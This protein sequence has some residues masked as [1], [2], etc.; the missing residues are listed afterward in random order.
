MKD[1]SRFERGGYI[2][3]DRKLVIRLEELIEHSFKSEHHPN[4]YA[5]EMKI[6]MKRLNSYTM[7]Y[8]GKTVNRMIEDR[9]HEEALK[10]LCS[11]KL[12]IKDITYL[13]GVNDPSWFSRCFKKYTGYSPKDWRRMNMGA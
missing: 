11:T 2:T 8:V 4:F 7:F 6:S 10:L 1:T 5:D 12:L 3:P 13:L 9:I